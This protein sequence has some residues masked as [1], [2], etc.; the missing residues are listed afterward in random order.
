MIFNKDFGFGRESLNFGCFL[1]FILNYFYYVYLGLRIRFFG[2][3]VVV[4]VCGEKED[5]GLEVGR[6]GMVIRGS[7][8]S[9]RFRV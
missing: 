1:R 3:L 2:I 6:F 7:V 4:L 9:F 8:S 5:S